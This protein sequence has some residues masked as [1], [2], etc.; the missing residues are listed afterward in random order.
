MMGG[1]PPLLL[2]AAGAAVGAA[3]AP[4]GGALTDYRSVALQGL[5]WAVSAAVEAPGG[6]L[7][8]PPALVGQTSLVSYNRTFDL[9]SGSAGVVVALLEA[10]DAAAAAERAGA[11]IAG[12]RPASFYLDAATRAGLLIAREAPAIVAAGSSTG[13]YHGGAA[14]MAFAL[15][16]LRA[17]ANESAAA[18]LTRGYDALVAYIL[19]RADGGNMNSFTG[20]R[21]GTAGIGL[22]L[23]TAWERNR[24][25]N[26]AFLPAAAAAGDFLL[27]AGIPTPGGGLKWMSGFGDLEAPNYAEG[28]AGVSYFLASLANATGDAA[29]YLDGGAL[30]GA[31]YLLSIANRTDG[32]C[33]IFHDNATAGLYYL[34]NCHGPPGTGRLFLRLAALTGNATWAA[35]AGEGAKAVT[36]LAPVAGGA[37]GGAFNFYVDFQKPQPNPLWNNVGLCDGGGAV[38]VYFL[39]LYAL[40]ARA[41]DLAFAVEVADDVVAR[42]TRVAPDELQ[43]VVTEWLEDPAVST[44]PQ[45]GYMQGSAAV[46]VA[47]L[48]LDAVVNRRPANPHIWLPD[49]LFAVAGWA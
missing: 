26:A 45:V 37:P 35:L 23:L 24:T 43:W 48:W 14:G 22:F 39:S 40:R 38:V 3:G 8:W 34:A 7:E 12:A 27:T 42:A 36:D 31:A 29:R 2:L 5:N 4:A 20:L 1:M 46:S 18:A 19:A 44:G 11:P 16:A 49:D 25:A 15:D 10:A 21:W 41:E 30:R 47:L 33:L 6:L 32:R 17:R 9:Y 13:L 28:T